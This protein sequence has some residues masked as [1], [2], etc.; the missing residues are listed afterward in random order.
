MLL[1]LLLNQQPGQAQIQ[2][3][4]MLFQEGDRLQ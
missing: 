1:L 2:Q 4:A 3:Q